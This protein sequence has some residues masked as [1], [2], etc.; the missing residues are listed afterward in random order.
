MFLKNATQKIRTSL[1]LQA[2]IGVGFYIILVIAIYNFLPR[3]IDWD[4]TYRPVGQALYQL[5]SPYSVEGFRAA[6]WAAL[7]SLPFAWLPD[8]IGRAAYFLMSLFAFMLVA[9][10]LGA[11][12]VTLAAFILSPPVIHCLLNA[13]IDW[14][15][16]VGFILPPPIGIF[17]VAVKPQMGWCVALFWVIQSLRGGKI[18]DTIYLVAPITL[19]ILISFAF[20]GF[21][22]TRFIE[23]MGYWWNASLWPASIPIG[24]VLLAFS[25]SKQRIEGAMAASP[26]LSPYVLLHS[27][28]GALV[29]LASKPIEMLAAVAGLW[30]LVIIRAFS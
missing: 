29:S 22:P 13:N 21:W 10:K 4:E 30:I 3:G 14:L 24:L 8:R 16:L 7:V 2:A 18:T 1:P 9:F 6:P 17:F 5:K 20:L 11:K 26:F 12:P 28:S 23:P 15:P 25:L 27:W 19:V